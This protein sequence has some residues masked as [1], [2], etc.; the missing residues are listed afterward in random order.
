MDCDD[1]LQ[2]LII[3]F[4]AIIDDHQ[5]RA[6]K[7]DKQK[8][9]ELLKIFQSASKHMTQVL[10]EV[11]TTSQKLGVQ[12]IINS[13]S[14]MSDKSKSDNFRDWI[15]FREYVNQLEYMRDVFGIVHNNIRV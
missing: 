7:M 15:I 1:R 4:S 6:M 2:R 8:Y 13:P 3:G 5:A 11:R 9:D 12:P 14:V 10:C